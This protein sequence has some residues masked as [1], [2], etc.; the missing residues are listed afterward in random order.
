[1]TRALSVAMWRESIARLGCVS[2][3]RLLELADED[4]VVVLLRHCQG[5]DR[6]RAETIGRAAG[7]ALLAAQ[8]GGWGGEAT[9]W[10]CPEWAEAPALAAA[11]EL[12]D[13]VAERLDTANG[14]ALHAAAVAWRASARIQGEA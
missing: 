9:A 10:R 6:A 3:A 14:T 13:L 2:W 7:D 1:M 12:F 8:S 4:G 11:R 5:L